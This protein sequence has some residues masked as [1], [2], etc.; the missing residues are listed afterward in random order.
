MIARVRNHRNR[1]PIVVTVYN[2]EA[3]SVHSDETLCNDIPHDLPGRV[4][5]YEQ[6]FPIRG[7]LCDGSRLID[8]PLHDMA[9]IRPSARSGRSKFTESPGRRDPR[10]VRLRVSGTTSMVKAS[11]FR[12]VTVRQALLTLMLSPTFRVG[13]TARAAMINPSVP[14]ERTIPTSSTIPVNIFPLSSTR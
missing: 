6:G 7:Y 5:P 12:T 13:M 1:K 2:C 14:A 9:N 10:L 8:M 11:G 3:H 4:E